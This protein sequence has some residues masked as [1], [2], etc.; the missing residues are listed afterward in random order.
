VDTT[1]RG[2]RGR[3]QGEIGRE[4][5]GDFTDKLWYHLQDCMQIH[6]SSHHNCLLL[7]L[8]ANWRVWGGLRES[9]DQEHCVSV[10]YSLILFHVFF[11]FLVCLLFC[12][13]LL[14]LRSEEL[15]LAIMCTWDFRCWGKRASKM[16]CS[17]Y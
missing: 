11:F 17:K 15:L 9:C 16:G 7:L 3:K 10:R 6:H 4:T 2:D 13:I 14:C 8:F 5:E 12:M 1:E